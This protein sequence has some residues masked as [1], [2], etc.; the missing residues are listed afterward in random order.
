M[1]LAGMMELRHKLR[2]KIEEAWIRLLRGCLPET[3]S[4]APIAPAWLRVLLESQNSPQ[5]TLDT[6]FSRGRRLA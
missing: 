4:P 1:T 6:L 3:P 5:L 2:H